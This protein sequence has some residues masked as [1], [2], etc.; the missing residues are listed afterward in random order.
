MCE[1]DKD[2]ECFLK[3]KAILFEKL[4]KSR[5]YMIFDEEAD[6]LNILAYYTLAIQVLRVDESLLSG[7]KTKFFD[8]FS[9]KVG[10]TK[11]TEF[12]A[13]LIG[14]IGKNEKYSKLISGVE[15]MEY[16][17]ATLLKGQERLGGRVIMLE[18]KDINYLLEFYSNFGFQKL[19]K[20]YEEG[21]LLQLIRILKED[22]L[23]EQ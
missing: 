20:D 22:E 19:E 13:I 16:C 7:R 15:V 18:C 9:S 14:Q 6:E 21:E 12:P 17:L 1:K 4:G 8:G 5:T 10:G 11:I 3:E 23:V 2:I